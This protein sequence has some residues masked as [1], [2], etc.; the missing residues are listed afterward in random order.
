[1]WQ[2]T[3]TLSDKDLFSNV[4]ELGKILGIAI[5]EAKYTGDLGFRR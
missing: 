2:N 5:M 1:M 4:E 3:A